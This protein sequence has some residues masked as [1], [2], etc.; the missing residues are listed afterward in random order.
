MTIR[1]FRRRR[2]PL[3]HRIVNVFAI[4]IRRRRAQGLVRGFKF[5]PERKSKKEKS[6][7]GSVTF[8]KNLFLA[9]DSVLMKNDQVEVKQNQCHRMYL[10]HEELAFQILDFL[11]EEEVS[12]GKP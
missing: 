4:E 2:H 7:F 11:E 6:I 9:K 5:S 10:A 3:H 8:L 12:R 1:I